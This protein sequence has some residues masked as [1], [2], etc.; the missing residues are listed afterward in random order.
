MAR[1]LRGLRAFLYA[2][3]SK[4]ELKRRR[5]VK[6]QVEAGTKVAAEFEVESLTIYDKDNDKSASV[7]GKKF[8][9]DWYQMMADL[10]AGK[11][12]LVIFW[13]IS[14]G[15][16]TTKEGIDFVDVCA[17]Q[18]VLVYVIDE[19]CEFDPREPRDRKRLIN[20]FADA[21][22]E[23]GQHRKRIVRDKQHI[24]D[25]GLPDGKIPFGHRRLYHERTRE[26]IRQ[27]PDPVNRDCIREGVQRVRKGQSLRR[28]LTDF[29][30]RHEHDRDCPRWIPVI[31]DGTPWRHDNLRRT[32]MNPAHIGMRRDPHWKSGSA[33][34]E[35][36][37]AA[38]APLFD[39]P[40]WITEWWAAYR[41]L[42]DDSRAASRSTQVEHLVSYFMT[43]HECD[44]R[45]AVG[46]PP[47]GKRN[48]RYS[49]RD[50]PKVQPDPAKGGPGCTSI[51]A[52]P[53]DDLISELVIKRL[54]QPEVIAAASHD[55]DAD[56]VAARAR[57]ASLRAKL[58]EFWASA[59]R[60]DGTGITLAQ[61]EQARNEIEP[62]IA[63]AK[64]AA[65]RAAAP[66]LLREFLSLTEGAGEEI[67]REV[68]YQ[69][70]T[71]E[72][73]RELVKLLFASIKLKRGRPGRVPFDPTRIEVTWRTW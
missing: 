41:I 8:R 26:L 47:G 38:W 25:Q 1:I 9:D 58:D 12:D 49:C 34:D 19:D 61:Y 54:A 39:D 3:V 71:L 65:E 73:R 57:A 70:L 56:A 13:E 67:V 69:E 44:R 40:E 63:A 10:E 24:L 62:Q 29:N 27:E 64:A 4:D 22:Y 14:R 15:S 48:P 2:R 7:H 72:A 31:T 50:D 66:P 51:V 59:M 16:R 53:V 32:L 36:I 11:A 28:I 35:F 5:S 33:G 45:T 6:Q 42:N 18:D 60:T 23:V 43:C 37:P 46:R 68:W 17:A 52:Q 20:M 30:R 21:E 55:D